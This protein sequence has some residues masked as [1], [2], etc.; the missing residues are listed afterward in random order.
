MVTLGHLFFFF[1]TPLCR[2]HIAFFLHQRNSPK[3]KCLIPAALFSFF[4]SFYKWQN[5]LIITKLAASQ[6]YTNKSTNINYSKIQTNWLVHLV[7]DYILPIT[8]ILVSINYL[9]L[10][11]ARN[12]EKYV[13]AMT[14]I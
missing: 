10:G 1:K 7:F 2:I 3:T 6:N 12:S 9:F 5:L 14:K 13:P 11:I 4:Q 8:P